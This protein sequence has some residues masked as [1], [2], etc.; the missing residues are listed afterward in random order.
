MAMDEEKKVDEKVEVK[1]EKK[2]PLKKWKKVLGITVATFAITLL[3]I[4]VILSILFGDE[5]IIVEIKL[6]TICPNT[7]P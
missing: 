7:M 4:G 1:V 5:L 2:A 6:T 3:I